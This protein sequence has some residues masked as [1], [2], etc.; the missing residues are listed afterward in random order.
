[1]VV[2]D[3]LVHGIAIREY[4]KQLPN[5]KI[6]TSTK[7]LEIT[8]KGIDVEGPDG[9]RTILADTIIYSVGQRPLREE[10]QALSGCAPEFYMLGDCTTPRNIFAATQSAYTIAR[11]LGRI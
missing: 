9:K 8:D 1:M 2:G 4:L 11:D 6:Y 10:A 3:P 7:A 5:M